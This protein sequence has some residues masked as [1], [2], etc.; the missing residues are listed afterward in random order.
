VELS[1]ANK[2]MLWVP[3]GMAHGF[4]S[5]EDGTDFLYKCTELYD[6]SC[7]HS[8]QWDDPDVG[9]VWP[10][11]GTIPQLSAKDQNAQSFAETAG[12]A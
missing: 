3:P 9:I 5:L 4:L 7:E 6:P 2:K 11:D 8:L 10:L 12:Y 1:A